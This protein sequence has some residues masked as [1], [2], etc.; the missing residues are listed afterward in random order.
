MHYNEH[1]DPKNYYKKL[2]LLFIPFFDT[3]HTFKGD[4]FTWNVAY[5]MHK[6]QINLLKK[7]LYIILIMI[8]FIRNLHIN[9]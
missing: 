1:Q 8:I 5:N 9:D 3:K 2:L 7:H 6:I 4:H